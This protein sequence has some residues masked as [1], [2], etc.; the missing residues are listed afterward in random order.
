MENLF[1]KYYE[2]GQITVEDRNGNSLGFRHTD[3]TAINKDHLDMLNGIFEQR[4]TV[5]AILHLPDKSP[6]TIP[7]MNAMTE[8]LLKLKIKEYANVYMTPNGMITYLKLPPTDSRVIKYFD[9]FVVV[10]AVPEQGRNEPCKCL[11]GK[12]YKNCCMNFAIK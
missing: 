9:S 2:N 5:M 11:S 6:H 12:K 4:Y 3:H 7:T 8:L 10:M 1:C